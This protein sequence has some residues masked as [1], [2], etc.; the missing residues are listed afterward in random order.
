MKVLPSDKIKEA[1]NILA[2]EAKVYAPMVQGDVSGYFRWTD[3]PIGE[4]ALDILNTYMSPKNI[5]MPQTEEMY[6]FLA[7]GKEAQVTDIA[8][9][10]GPRVIFGIRSCDLQALHALDLV[11][12]TKGY[13]DE[14][15]KARRQE[16]AVIARACYQ[17]GPAC[18]C[19][20]MGVD[21]LNPQADVVMHDLG[22]Q[23]FAWEPKTPKGED[24]TAKLQGVLVEKDVTLPQAAEMQTKVDI[25]GLSE[26]L[27]GMFEHPIWDELS[28][29]C[30]NCG[31]CTYVCPTCYCFDIQVTT[32]GEAGSRFRCW[33]SCMYKEYTQMAG[34]HNPREYKKERFRQ[35]F[36]H[37]LQYFNERYNANL[38]I[39]CGRCVIM[40]PNGVNVLEVINKL[41]EV[42][43]DA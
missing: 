16:L 5:V 4:L 28:S 27:A 17:P 22:R 34:G 19:E 3:N 32:R 35:R 24:I 42:P 20:S 8:I 33:D 9:A 41:K 1:L 39:G 13:E 11:F 6:K 26:K 7:P 18:F 29:R 2:R 23:D 12:L 37:K 40:C 14:F 10:E 36:L 38:C 30:M 31:V 43:L 15:Y 25:T 21:R